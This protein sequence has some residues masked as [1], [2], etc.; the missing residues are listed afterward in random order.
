GELND[1]GATALIARCRDAAQ[2]LA[3]QLP[4]LLPAADT[5]APS[6]RPRGLVRARG[7]RRNSRGAARY[8]RSRGVERPQPRTGRGRLLRARHAA[9]LPLDQRARRRTAD[10][11][12]FGRDGARPAALG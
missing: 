6:E 8:R 5:E 2:R 3:P 10:T 7:K 4:A 9:E 12:A 1:G 11:H